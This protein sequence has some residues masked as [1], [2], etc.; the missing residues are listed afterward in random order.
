MESIRKI[1]RE[2]AVKGM[3]NEHSLFA[4]IDTAEAEIENI[5]NAEITQIPDHLVAAIVGLLLPH[6]PDLTA[7]RLLAA[8]NTLHADSCMPEPL[9]VDKHT[10]CKLLGISIATL[11][12][13]LKDRQL[14]SVRIRGSVRI[15]ADA[16]NQLMRPM[17]VEDD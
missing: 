10:A 5:I 13:M 17:E 9:V 11:N 8:L 2:V 4:T 1:I 3:S 14:P 12:R 6:F 15:P 7:E 16:I